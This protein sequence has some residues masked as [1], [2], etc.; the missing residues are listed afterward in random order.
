VGEV[1]LD[2]HSEEVVGVGRAV[3]RAAGI[4]KGVGVGTGASHK[5]VHIQ[6]GAAP[7]TCH[8]WKVK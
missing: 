7:N 3:V 8:Y 1:Q 6:D 5:E 4:V 2:W